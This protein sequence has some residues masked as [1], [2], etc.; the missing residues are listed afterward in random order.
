MEALHSYSTILG[1]IVV[2]QNKIQARQGRRLVIGPSSARAPLQ[3]SWRADENDRVDTYSTDD[4]NDEES[5]DTSESGEFDGDESQSDSITMERSELE[6]Q[7]TLY[8]LY[9]GKRG[10]GSQ[11]SIVPEPISKRE[12]DTHQEKFR[13]LLHYLE[14]RVSKA[15][16]AISFASAKQKNSI[17]VQN[18]ISDDRS[19]GSEFQI[20][21]R[22][23]FGL[24]RNIQTSADASQ[25]PP[26]SKKSLPEN[27]LQPGALRE[28]VRILDPQLSPPASPPWSSDGEQDDELQLQLLEQ[29]NKRKLMARMAQEKDINGPR[30]PRKDAETE[31]SLIPQP[32]RTNI[33][34]TFTLLGISGN[35]D[36]D[37]P[38]ESPSS[39]AITRNYDYGLN[40]DASADEDTSLRSALSIIKRAL[41]IHDE[42]LLTIDNL[43]EYVSKIKEAKA[44]KPRSQIIHRVSQGK[45]TKIYL[46]P[47]RWV[48]GESAAREALVGNL[49][50]G[51]IRPYLSKHPEIS[52]VVY[53][54]Y[55]GSQ[56]SGI[57][58]DDEHEGV[59]SQPRHHSETI[60]P[61]SDD[62]MAAIDTFSGH[63]RFNIHARG[64][65]REAILSRPHVAIYHARG[66]ALRTFLET[67]NNKQQGHFKLLLSYI[68]TE[69]D[70]EYN[71]VDNMIINGKIFH[72]YIKYLFKPGDVVVQ[73]NYQ[74][75]RGYMCTSWL[76]GEES[77]PDNRIGSDKKSDINKWELELQ[78]WAFDGNFSRER[79]KL[80]LK[81]E[82][83][84]LSHKIIDDLSVRPL[85]FV[86]ASTVERLRRRGDWFWKCRIRHMV[87]YHEENERGFQDSSHERY[88]IDMKMYRE[89]HKREK[90][91]VSSDDLGPEVLKQNDP[92][93]DKF[94]YLMPL[95]IKGYNL[96]KKKW[97]D[98]DVDKI[99][100]VTWNRTAFESLVINPKTKRLIQALISNQIE[101]EKS[102]DLIT[103]KGNGL[104]MLLHGGP[105]TGKTL[106]AESVA[107]IAK[108]P[109]YP[110]TCGDIGTEPEAVENYLESVLHLGKTWGCVVL[111]DEADVF[112]EQR[113]LEDLQRNALVSV[114]LRVLE[115][116]D[117]I[118]V[119][120]SNRVGTFDEAFKSRIQL[121]IHYA[122]LTQ[123]QRT[124]IWD[125]FIKRLKELDEEGMDLVDLEDNIEE[126]A[127]NKLNGREI[128]NVITTARQYSRWER[129]Q[130]GQ[131]NYKLNY[132]MMKQLIETTGEFDRYIEKLNG[133]YT[134]DQ[135][136]EDEGWR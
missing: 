101:G 62:L 7:N 127:K 11:H 122:N 35:E 14:E 40:L 119:L 136:A 23:L 100:E 37:N 120:T 85:A 114:F 99:K 43:R 124:K 71:A 82:S 128:R 58:S 1:H 32:P 19:R 108:K 118:L 96:K 25:N 39:N 61:I 24:S 68:L 67:L 44:V 22:N 109:L 16:Q 53:L 87:S 20:N 107:E 45:S 135:L 121:A 94:I 21:N 31:S 72:R 6:E 103:G 126:L 105:G 50:I 130:K 63:F 97:V 28:G 93:D 5:I 115:Y 92:P 60:D 17:L 8:S 49:P 133:G 15:S 83:N 66:E 113:S 29:Q 12:A 117:G 131:E 88:M 102:T 47:P 56:P 13:P 48:A 116:Y 79:S 110:V 64:S 73:G 2:V 125:N 89:L 70:G 98:L 84:D 18:T 106:T 129:Q 111:L 74:D 52:F 134:Q 86:N 90:H 59:D 42:S 3:H 30:G 123:H 10:Q 26:P 51:N 55:D 27:T 95:T 77:K 38:W 112:L 75:S 34:E 132:A 80:T 57:N 69:Y 54:D 81:F 46:D 91:I 36:N 4:E 41:D 76:K 65:T 9:Q 78:H 33:A 104:I